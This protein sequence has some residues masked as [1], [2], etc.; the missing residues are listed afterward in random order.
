MP[1]YAMK[2]GGVDKVDLLQE[3]GSPKELHCRSCE[4]LWRA[5]VVRGRLYRFGGLCGNYRHTL[6]F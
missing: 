1:T 2:K 5:W 4:S 6:S 3:P